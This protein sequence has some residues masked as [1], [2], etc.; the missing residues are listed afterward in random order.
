MAIQRTAIAREKLLRAA[1]DLFR[2]EGYS[3]TTVD[4][5]CEAAGVTKG[6][7]FHHFPSKESLA[8]ECLNQWNC[9]AAAMESAAPFHAVS[10]PLKRA[11]AFM[12]FY[13]GLFSNP[14]LIKSCLAGTTVQEVA[15]T[16]PSLR[17]AANACFLQ[18]EI[19]FKGILDA[20]CK[21]KRR[22]PDTASLARLWMAAI[23]GSL[24]LAKAS[25]DDAVIRTSLEHVRDYIMPTLAGASRRA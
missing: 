6:A 21:G 24:I 13:I 14:H 11:R 7:F 25:G 5:I 12:D 18:A 16:H 1:T 15:D 8:E 9:Q 20:A 2:R 4:T 19:R 22:K 17:E 3:A 10:N 23:Q